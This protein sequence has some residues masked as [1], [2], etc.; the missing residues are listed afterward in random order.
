M[1]RTEQILKLDDEKRVLFN[2]LAKIEK[3][4]LKLNVDE[5]EI[6]KRVKEICD[7]QQGLIDNLGNKEAV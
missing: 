1:A 3:Q 5:Y 6:N 4:R 2:K 7:I